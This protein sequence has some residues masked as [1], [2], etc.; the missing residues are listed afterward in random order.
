MENKNQELE[1]L[2]KR[3]TEKLERWEIEKLR[4]LKLQTRKV[5]KPKLRK[6]E[7]PKNFDFLIF[8]LFSSSFEG[9]LWNKNPQ[10]RQTDRTK[11]ETYFFVL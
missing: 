6:M 2:R 4:K 7:N 5:M 9:Y 1:K 3:K 11:R 8:Q 10:R